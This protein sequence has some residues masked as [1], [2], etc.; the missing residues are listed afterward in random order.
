MG[1]CRKKCCQLPACPFTVSP[2]SANNPAVLG[3][4]Q[5]QFSLTAQRP[6]YAG[7]QIAISYQYQLSVIT[8]QFMIIPLCLTDI[9]AEP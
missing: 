5:N 7:A 3:E 4:T 2:R 8:Y 6:V 9:E 1:S